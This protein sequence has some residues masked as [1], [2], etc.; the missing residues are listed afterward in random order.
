MT[1]GGRLLQ[2]QA[3]RAVLQSSRLHCCQ[4]YLHYII[5]WHIIITYYIFT[6]NQY[7]V[8][9]HTWHSPGVQK[10]N[11][12]KNILNYIFFQS[13]DTSYNLIIN[14]CY[15]INNYLIKSLS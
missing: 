1:V 15:H 2:H 8:H 6:I 4:M 3:Y 13:I 10:K 9:V 11:S 7:T 5:H 14:Q 12:K